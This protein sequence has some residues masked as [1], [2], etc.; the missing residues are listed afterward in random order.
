MLELPLL[1]M[2][3]NCPI[4]TSSLKSCFNYALYISSVNIYNGWDWLPHSIFHDAI[5]CA[6]LGWIWVKASSTRTRVCAQ[7][8][9]TWKHIADEDVAQEFGPQVSPTTSHARHMFIWLCDDMRSKSY[10]LDSRYTM[11]QQVAM[12][13]FTIW[14]NCR[15]FLVQYV[16]QHLGEMVSHHFHTVLRDL[17]SFAMEMIKPPSFY[18]ISSEILKNMN[19]YPWF[20]DCNGVIDRKRIPLWYQQRKLFI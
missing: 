15:N 16:F 5:R 8:V 7:L 3:L 18:E 14:Y 9:F 13:L 10:F 17:A 19:Y 11:Y 1:L 20:K 2:V 6:G 12:F 4:S